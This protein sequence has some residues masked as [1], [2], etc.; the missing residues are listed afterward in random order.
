VPKLDLLQGTLDLMVLQTLH[1]EGSAHGYGIARRIEQVSGKELMLNQ[2]TIHASLVRL[3]R[4]GWIQSSWGLSIRNRRARFYTITHLGINQ[5]GAGIHYWGRLTG[6]MDRILA[7]GQAP[8]EEKGH[9][10]GRLLGRR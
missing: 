3:E 4:R 7:M 6:V 1:V 5:L 2:G 10:L 8:V 9:G